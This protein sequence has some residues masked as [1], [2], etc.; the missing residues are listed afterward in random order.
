MRK[1]PKHQRIKEKKVD[2]FDKKVKHFQ[3]LV[4]TGKIKLGRNLG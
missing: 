1:N 3:D 2:K 4:A